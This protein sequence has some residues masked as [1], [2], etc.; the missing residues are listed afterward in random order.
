M[1]L[2]VV[3]Y[4][5]I[6]SRFNKYNNDLLSWIDSQLLLSQSCQPSG[7]F[8]GSVIQGINYYVNKN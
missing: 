3:C 4:I 7:L 8:L 1:R 2:K 6:S 5:I